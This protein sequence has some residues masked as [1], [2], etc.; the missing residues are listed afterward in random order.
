MPQEAIKESF[1][2]ESLDHGQIDRCQEGRREAALDSQELDFW[3]ATG[4]SFCERQLEGAPKL[5]LPS[6]MLRYFT[7]ILL[8]HF[9][10]DPKEP[11]SG[12]IIW[13][14]P[15][16]CRLTYQ[17]RCAQQSLP[18]RELCCCSPRA[19]LHCELSNRAD[20]EF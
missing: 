19:V 16:G 13:L 12:S 18:R 9:W 3:L 5:Q 6:Y 4:D 17:S 11:K 15:L 2:T 8:V 20:D 1:Q 14:G 10:N 7:S